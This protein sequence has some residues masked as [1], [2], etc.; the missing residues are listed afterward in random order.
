MATMQDEEMNYLFNVEMYGTMAQEEV[1]INITE[2]IDLTAYKLT[3]EPQGNMATVSA[4]VEEKEIFFWLD[5]NQGEEGVYPAAAASNI[6]YG[7]DQLQPAA[8]TFIV[9]SEEE[10]AKE[11]LASFISTPDAE[12]NAIMYNFT[13]IPGDKPAEATKH[14]VT[15]VVTPEGAGTVTGA[16]EYEDGAEVTVTATENGDEWLFMGW[17]DAATNDFVAYD[18]EYSFTITEDVTLIAYY[19]PAMEGE[20]NDLVIGENTL[21]ASAQLSIGLLKMNLVLGEEEEGR[22]WLAE[23]STLTV[24]DKA[25]ILVEGVA[26]VDV[27]NHFAATS[28]VAQYNDALYYI[29]VVMYAPATGVDNINTTVVPVKMI[30][31]GQLIIMNGDAK[32]NVQGA[33]VK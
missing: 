22:Y 28:F 2:T 19:L 31:N 8:N 4:F 23:E 16:G 25:A 3:I 27:A 21:T 24:D 1:E 12:G 15:I 32:Y 17:V 30:E 33:L 10:G 20:S 13:L 29:S 11:L 26:Q 9:Y 6:W 7:D 5:L 18:Y 14:T